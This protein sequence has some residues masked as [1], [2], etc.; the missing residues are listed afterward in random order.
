MNSYKTHIEIEVEVFFD[1]QPY[2]P[3]TLTYPGCPFAI[4]NLYVEY[5]GNEYDVNKETLEHLEQE[6]IESLEAGDERI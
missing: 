4:E 3:Q 6:A 5:K 1:V 2:E